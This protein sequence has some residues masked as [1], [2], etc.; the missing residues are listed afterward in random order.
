[1]F[2]ACFVI[3][4]RGKKLYTH[5]VGLITL[6]AWE[7]SMLWLYL[8]T[9]KL[10][11]ASSPRSYM[12]CECIV[13]REKRVIVTQQYHTSV[14]SDGR[15][16][17]VRRTKGTAVANRKKKQANWPDVEMHH[18]RFVDNYD[19]AVVVI[20]RWRDNVDSGRSSCFEAA[21]NQAGL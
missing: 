9:E 3:A 11:T 21:E 6:Q 19:D 5:D 16:A 20:E 15:I 10:L 4:N 1:M 12:V 17:A 2:F 13:T 18:V 8:M 7:S 14:S